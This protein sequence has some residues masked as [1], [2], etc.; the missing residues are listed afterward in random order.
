[1]P[2]E[3]I[4]LL[5]GRL[6]EAAVRR[7]ALEVETI[8]PFEFAIT[9]LPISVAALMHTRW[10]ERK[11]EWHSDW[12]F[13]RVLLPGY[14]QGDPASLTAKFGTPFELGPK[15]I[16]DLAEHLGLGKRKAVALDTYNIEILAEINHA[17]RMGVDAIL[18]QAAHYRESGAELIDVGG[19]PGE[20]WAG[21]GEAVQ[22]LRHE[23]FRV[24]IDS[25]DRHEVE[26]AVEAGAELILSANSSNIEWVRRCPVEV[27]AIPD[28]H[29]CLDT[30]QPTIDALREAGC[31]FRIDPILE[32]V[33][34]GFAA[35]LDRYQV[36]RQ[37]WPDL[38]VMMGI[39]NVTELA[40]V[41]SAG[42]NLLLAGICGELGITSVLTTEVARWCGSA[43]REFDRARRIV[44]Y[45]VE[46]Q[47]IAKHVDS[48]LVMLRDAKVRNYG[49]EALSA[50]AAQL[51][52]P[53]F[54]IF[55]EQG[56]VHLMNRDG[57]WQ[58]TDPYEVYDRMAESSEPL[59]AAHAFYLG[60]EMAKAMT[61]LTLNK[62]Y[63]QDQPLN[64]GLLTRDETSAIE[65]R[66]RE[67]KT[68]TERVEE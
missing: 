33:G 56:V 44:K 9:V 11:L 24:S 22:A 65:R 38:P 7:T 52:D 34:I 68:G 19:I 53:N 18:R 63:R 27:V 14:C 23:G 32:P 12:Q 4:L 49:A 15:E 8:A 58:G 26:A 25:F 35:S 61:A 16:L 40:E 51:K 64:W 48:S 43:V 39:G 21:V 54:R 66:H 37:R 1:M 50:L 42:V 3:R 47:T 17:P 2:R 13:D 20:S 62:E 55:A 5:T 59:S 57:H 31:R 6:A 67:A 28:D 41:D 46:H 45:A 36:A 30:L 29:R 60:F 10:V